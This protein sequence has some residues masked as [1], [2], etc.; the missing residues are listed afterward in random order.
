MKLKFISE[1]TLQDLRVNYEAYKEHYHNQ[2]DEWFDSYFAEEGRVL[3]SHI[4]FE[5]P[6]FS[7][8]EDYV[9]SDQENV[10]IVY[11]AL[12]DL[13]LAQATQERLWAGLAHV[14]FREY[15]YYRIGEDLRKGNDKRINSALFFKHSAKRSLFVHILARLW[16]VGHMTYDESHEENP[17][18]LTDFFTAKDFSARCVVFFS[19]NFTSNRNITLGILRSLYKL[20]QEGINILR[21]HFTESTRYLNIVGGA[22]VLDMLTVNEVEEMVTERLRKVLGIRGKEHV[23]M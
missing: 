5:M 17:F 23:T 15:T 14:Q 16:W 9:K 21:D 18:W 12:Q 1:N 10:K 2:N 20:E 11:K 3:G 22:M 19:S 6:D 7:F 13:T 8:D 4:E